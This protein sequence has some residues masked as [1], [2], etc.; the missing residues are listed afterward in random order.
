WS[1]WIGGRGV[2]VRTCELAH[3][4]NSTDAARIV[5]RRAMRA[6]AAA[7]GG[8][9]PVWAGPR[10]HGATRNAPRPPSA[11][12]AV[13][14]DHLAVDVAGLL[15]A[16]EGDQRRHLVRGP[17]AAGRDDLADHRRIERGLAHA[18]GDHARGDHVGGDA[19]RA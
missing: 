13:D 2:P 8:S 17:G 6:M 18:S 1:G 3:A 10:E 5:S 12:A 15:R 14:A 19:A 16:Q 4:A 9:W 11:H 7:P